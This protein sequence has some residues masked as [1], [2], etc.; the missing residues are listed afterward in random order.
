MESSPERRVKRRSQKKT[1]LGRRLLESDQESRQQGQSG[2]SKQSWSSAE[3]EAGE[4]GV[5][6]VV[7]RFAGDDGPIALA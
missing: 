2:A 7:G 3:M 1:W 4:S 6:R 5:E